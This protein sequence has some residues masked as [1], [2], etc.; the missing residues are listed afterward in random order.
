MF[1]LNNQGIL[2]ELIVD[3]MADRKRAKNEMLRLQNEFEQTKD[4]SLV[5]KI[6]ALNNSQMAA[7]I[8]LNSLYG[9][10]ANEGFRFFNP[11]VAESITITG[12][13]ILK[14]IEQQI[15]I[16]L[17]RRFKTTGHNYL[18]YVD[19]DSVYLNM[20]PVVEQFLSG[21]DVPKKVKALEK[22]AVDILQE[23]I[24]KICAG[25]SEQLNFF[26]NS[27][28]FKLEAVGDKAIWIAKKKYVVRVHS[29]EGVTYAKPK[30]KVMG[31]EMVRSSTPAFIREKLRD[32][33]PKVFDGTESEIQSYIAGV[34]DQF[35]S[36]P[37]E[38]QAF[39]RSAN[40]LEEY[41]D[42]N[43]I[44]KQ[45]CPIQVRGVLLYN[46]YIRNKGLNA[47]YPYIQEGDRIRF[48]YLKMP[49]PMREN[50]MAIPADGKLP[51]EFNLEKY[52]DIETQFDKSFISAM[53]II[54]DPIG[55]SVVEQSSL[56]DFFG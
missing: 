30:M 10:T 29:S 2:P 42:V 38:Q 3:M 31:L 26:E 25:V 49:N 41:S 6:S 50:I 20:E 13:F 32:A 24:N 35:Y 46:D 33:L 1:K 11:D 17:N 12:Q 15:D 19:T 21:V 55:W 44:Y 8:A 22:V 56:E 5:G 52:V 39:P 9:A 53:K 7:K 51:V 23:E 14:N 34:R 37:T 45:G 18:V 40:N 47:K 16:A 4:Q 54:L 36:L 43:T 28:H 27:I 48:F